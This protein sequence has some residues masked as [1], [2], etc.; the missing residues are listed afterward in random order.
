M[1]THWGKGN[2]C[3]RSVFTRFQ[4]AKWGIE[5]SFSTPGQ[6]THLSSNKPVCMSQNNQGS[7]MFVIGLFPFLR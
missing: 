3:Q 6:M 4:A 7:R 2:V 1:L 5:V